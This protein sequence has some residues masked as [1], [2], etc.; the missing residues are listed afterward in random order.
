MYIILYLL[1]VEGWREQ[2][3]DDYIFFRPATQDNKIADEDDVTVEDID[4]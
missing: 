4:V 3:E 2:R 1:Q